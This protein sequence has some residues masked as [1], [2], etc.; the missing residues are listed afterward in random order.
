[1]R[2]LLFDLDPRTPD[3]NIR[4]RNDVWRKPFFP[5]PPLEYS[6]SP[7]LQEARFHW[8]VNLTK[9]DLWKRWRTLSQASLLEG[10][11]LENAQKIFDEATDAADKDENGK[12]IVGGVTILA[13]IERIDA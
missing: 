5:K 13:W 1:M 2:Q 4:F 10:Q 3:E 7:G 8:Q 12:I 9:E 6:Q 11:D